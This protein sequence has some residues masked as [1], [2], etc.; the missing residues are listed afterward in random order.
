MTARGTTVGVATPTA[1]RTGRSVR[2]PTRRPARFGPIVGAT[3]MDRLPSPEALGEIGLRA[4]AYLAANRRFRE[5]RTSGIREGELAARRALKAFL[6]DSGACSP[7]GWPEETTR[8]L[9]V[10][11]EIIFAGVLN[12]P[13]PEHFPELERLVQDHLCSCPPDPPPARKVSDDTLNRSD[14]TADQRKGPASS[15]GTRPDS[16]RSTSSR[17]PG[18]RPVETDEKEDQRIAEA[19]GSNAYKT[20]ESLARAL[21]ISKRA[22]KLAIDR[23]RHRK[24]P[25]KTPRQKPRQ[26]D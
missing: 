19:W 21:G 4:L 3:M 24:E 1:K 11:C 9:S 5:H 16:E 26:E 18:G 17:R 14:P 7:V 20:H 15:M 8:V 6:R 2:T 13:Q 12:G 23:H 22:V 10:L 25:G